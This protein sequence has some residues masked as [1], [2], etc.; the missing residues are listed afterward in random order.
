ML[1]CFYGMNRDYWG[2][3]KCVILFVEKIFKILKKRKKRNRICNSEREKKRTRRMRKRENAKHKITKK[4][5]S[6]SLKS[7]KEEQK[8]RERVI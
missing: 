7:L 2:I 3:I 5:R 4:R 6:F 1:D 8:R